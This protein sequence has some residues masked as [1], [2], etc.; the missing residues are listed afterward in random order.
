MST[1]PKLP[2]EKNYQSK[3]RKATTRDRGGMVGRRSPGKHQEKS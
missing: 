2:G 1:L 3:D